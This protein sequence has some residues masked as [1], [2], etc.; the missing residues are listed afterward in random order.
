MDKDPGYA[1]FH[2]ADSVECVHRD[3]RQVLPIARDDLIRIERNGAPVSGEAELRGAL[4]E[5][6]DA[7]PRRLAEMKLLGADDRADHQ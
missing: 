1:M 3:Q 4:A 5:H 6:I 2:G 7:M